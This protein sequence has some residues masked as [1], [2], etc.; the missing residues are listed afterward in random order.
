[1]AKAGREASKW[2]RQF[3]FNTSRYKQY[4]LYHDDCY[5]ET[6]AVKVRVD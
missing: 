2:V 4:G 6:K 5:D 1:M 3:I